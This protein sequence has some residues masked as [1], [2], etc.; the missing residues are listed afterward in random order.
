VKNITKKKRGKIFWID[1]WQKKEGAFF[2]QR[3]L[4]KMYGKE[5]MRK[6]RN[7]KSELLN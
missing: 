6:K 3:V 5:A 7:E 1:D 4:Q 2:R